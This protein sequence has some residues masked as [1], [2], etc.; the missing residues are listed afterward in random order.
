MWVYIEATNIDL[1][2]TKLFNT[3]S[4]KGD[5]LKTYETKNGTKTTYTTAEFN[6]LQEATVALSFKTQHQ[7]RTT[8]ANA[9]LA[10]AWQALKASGVVA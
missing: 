5:T 2:V 6:A 8:T 10:N 3:T 1:Q 4:L 9:E 7:H